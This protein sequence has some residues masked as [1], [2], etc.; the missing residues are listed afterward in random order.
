MHRKLT[1]REVLLFQGRLRLPG[2]TDYAVIKDRV[3]H[4][5]ELLEIAHVAN[6]QIGDAVRKVL[7]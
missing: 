3:E 5:M 1:V 4:V 2:N 6:V 7:L